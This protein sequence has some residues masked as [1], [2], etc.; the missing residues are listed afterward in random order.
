MEG[1]PKSCRRALEL[2]RVG[3]PV[4]VLSIFLWTLSNINNSDLFKVHNSHP[5]RMI[6]RQKDLYNFKEVHGWRQT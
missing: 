1:M 5:Y 2:Q 4:I 6:G 3:K